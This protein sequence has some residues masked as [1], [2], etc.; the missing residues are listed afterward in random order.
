MNIPDSKWQKSQIEQHL[1]N[2][3]GIVGQFVKQTTISQVQQLEKFLP[4]IFWRWFFLFPDG[5]RLPSP[6]LNLKTLIITEDWPENGLF[7]CVPKIEPSENNHLNVTLTV[8]FIDYKQ[9]PFLTDLNN[10]QNKKPLQYNF[11]PDYFRD[12]IKFAELFQSPSL[13]ST[14]DKYLTQLLNTYIQ[15]KLLAWYKEDLF[16]NLGFS[17]NSWID[18][19]LEILKEIAKKEY[20]DTQFIL[21]PFMEKMNRVIPEYGLKT[22]Q[23][24]INQ[25]DTPQYLTTYLFWVNLN[26]FL[27]IPLSLYWNLLAPSFLEAEN[28]YEDVGDL[29]EKS[30]KDPHPL[31]CPATFL[32]ATG[33]GRIALT[34]L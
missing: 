23:L 18:F 31:F 24:N 19:W 26:R 6:F 27:I 2:F 28:F 10:M 30:Y 25:G 22:S 15:H 32:S 11:G 21:D 1:K 29:L 20:F 12:L 13:K 17:E 7:L 16:I 34:K 33:F 3:P 5:D 14:D 4:F 8:D 9:Q